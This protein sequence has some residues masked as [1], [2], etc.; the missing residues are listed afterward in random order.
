M[1]EF[2]VFTITVLISLSRITPFMFLWI[3]S[4]FDE[5]STTLQ[6]FK[7][8]GSSDRTAFS[9]IF[10]K[11]SANKCY[12]LRSFEAKLMARDSSST[13]PML[14]CGKRISLTT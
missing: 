14:G 6:N 10:M 11:S 12:T 2:L 7:I 13:T 4:F 5:R 3:S 9:K 1:S 8:V